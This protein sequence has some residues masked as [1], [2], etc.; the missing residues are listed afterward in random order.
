[1]NLTTKLNFK[2]IGIVL[3]LLTTVTAYNHWLSLE[4]ENEKNVQWLVE[5][6]DFLVKKKPDGSFLDIALKQ[7][8]ENLS[9]QQQILSVNQEL[10][11]VL[12]AIL[13]PTNIIKFGFYSRQH[14]SIVGIGPH[15]DIS[16]LFGVAPSRFQY[17]HDVNTEQ[18][19]EIKNSL[20]WH[21][22]STLIY[23]RPITHDGILIG[24]AFAAI[25]QDAVYTTI[26]KRTANT[27][28]AASL[29][30]LVCVMV[31]RE[32]FVKLKKD[33]LL[34]AERILDGHTFN[35]NSELAEFTPILQH[36]SEQTEKMTRL[37]RLN[38]IGEMAAG[39][40][41]E[42]RNPMTTVRGLLQ[43]M[44]R[45]QEFIHHKDRFALMIDELDRANSIITEF[46]SLAKNKA[47]N[48]TECNLNDIIRALHPLLMSDALRNNCEIEFSLGDIPTSLLDKDSIRQLMLN[49]VRNG[50][51][52]M[53]TGGLIHIITERD[54]QKVLLSIKDQGIGIVPENTE[55]LGTPFFTTKENG[56]G[57]GLAVCYRI[58]HRHSAT[59]SVKS[60]LGKGTAFIVE[61]DSIQ[62]NTSHS[63]RNTSM[64]SKIEVMEDA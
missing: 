40:A 17:I 12:Q 9:T 2:I 53:P 14:E 49:M 5:I 37:D 51:D 15:P 54:G 47:M 16:L 6:T 46:L 27:F 45:K 64:T 63:I 60:E 58:V 35:F 8:I 30:L 3:L 32:L 36:I 19:I 7:N 10:Q 23:V 61:F 21:G 62:S 57:L 25:N 42:V 41:H 13:V 18:L 4:K 28:F 59:I 29:M 1:M 26:W 52:A 39:I 22:A 33:L 24:H 31:F 44:G 11:P 50:I 55:K 20:L 38:I 43:F 48:F 56:T 34:F